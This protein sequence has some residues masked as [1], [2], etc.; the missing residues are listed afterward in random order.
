MKR[1][2]SLVV[3]LAFSG[4]SGWALAA[5]EKMPQSGTSGGYETEVQGGSAGSSSGSGG[6]ASTAMP[7]FSQAD[8]DS[9]GAIDSSEAGAISGLDLST[10][11]SNSDGQLSRTEYEAATLRQGSKGSSGSSGS[12]S[13]ALSR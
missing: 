6:A 4:V 1:S 12:S 2:M 11:D 13:D 9:N 7:S 10:A 5:D 3:V 8:S